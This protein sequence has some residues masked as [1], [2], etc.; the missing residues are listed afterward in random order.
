MEVVKATAKALINR[1]I[2]KKN[3]GIVYKRTGNRNTLH[4]TARKL[5]YFFVKLIAQP[6]L[7][8]SLLYF[9]SA[10]IF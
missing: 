9:R 4:L 10:F 5:I 3:I 7:F 8:K 2:D 1:L 6:H